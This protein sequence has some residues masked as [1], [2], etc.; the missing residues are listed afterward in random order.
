M[1]QMLCLLI[2]CLLFALSPTSYGQEA[3]RLGSSISVCVDPPSSSIVA[4]NEIEKSNHAECKTWSRYASPTAAVA[5][6]SF[7]DDE[8]TPSTPAVNLF[9]GHIVSKWT[10]QTQKSIT[11]LN[12]FDNFRAMGLREVGTGEPRTDALIVWRGGVVGIVIGDE[13][14]VD[15]AVTD[16]QKLTVLYP[17]DGRCGELNRLNGQVLD[18]KMPTPGKYKLL[19]LGPPA[20][21]WNHW[22]EGDDHETQSDP[23]VV[24]NGAYKYRIDFSPLDFGPLVGKA[25]ANRRAL[26]VTEA[27]KY[28]PQLGL[29]RVV[30]LAS[31]VARFVENDG[32]DVGANIAKELTLQ[33]QSSRVEKTLTANRILSYSKLEDL[34]ADHGA[35]QLLGGSNWTL[36]PFVSF[37][38]AQPGCGAL[39]TIIYTYTNG[40][41]NIIAAWSRGFRARSELTGGRMTISDDGDCSVSD[42]VAL[43]LDP[44]TVPRLGASGASSVAAR[45]T[46]LDLG[47]STVGFLETFGPEQKFFSWVLEKRLRE[48]L[49]RVVAQVNETVSLRDFSVTEVSRGLA[50]MLF[51]CRLSQNCQG[52]LAF[53]Q[54]RAIAAR[55]GLPPDA[56]RSKVEVIFNDARG[57]TYYVPIQLLMAD[58]GTVFGETMQTVHPLPYTLAPAQTSCVRNWSVGLIVKDQPTLSEK[59]RMSWVHPLLRSGKH[60][61]DEI[62]SLDGLKAYLRNSVQ[63]PVPEAFVLLAHHGRGDIG[64]S[65]MTPQMSRVVPANIQRTFA[66]GSFGLLAACSIGALGDSS[67]D[68]GTG[69]GNS[70]LL[71]ELNRRNLF[72][73]IVSPFKVPEPLAKSFM[74]HFQQVVSALDEDRTLNYVFAKTR[75]LV[76]EKANTLGVASGADLFMLVGNGDL[77]VCRP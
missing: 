60:S 42:E 32:S 14:R 69:I 44:S 74:D 73:A 66:K 68:P 38:A 53:E 40:L 67:F 7:K 13:N 47:Q 58:A 59:W 75:T 29:L 71:N 65:E 64:D 48:H 24:E 55:N 63:R 49:P 10:G 2:V 20:Y 21:F 52:Q 34:A 30:V 61:A 6:D 31:G 17:S 26:S 5:A 12:L 18:A 46:F 16:L 70:E 33:V 39:K 25:P 50:E 54:L 41:A 72:A 3:L 19:V 45:I 22:I 36:G 28:R 27:R 9:A 57:G 56:P 23:I 77:T 1:H 51:T 62:Y 8:C 15:N 37:Y 43:R 11:T 76:K 35:L 4:R